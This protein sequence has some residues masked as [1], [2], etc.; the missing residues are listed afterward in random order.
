MAQDNVFN[1]KAVRGAVVH[2]PCAACSVRD[3][4]ICNVLNDEQLNRFTDMVQDVLNIN[5]VKAFLQL[6][7]LR[8]R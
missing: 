2:A 1:L 7:G 5:Q 4:S 3:L 6:E 8:I